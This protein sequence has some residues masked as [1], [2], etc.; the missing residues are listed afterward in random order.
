MKINAVVVDDEKEA[1]EGVS[2]LLQQDSAIKIAAICGDGVSAIEQIN[3]FEPQLLLLDIQMPDINGF[4]VLNS[5]KKMPEAV[6]FVTA[7]DQFALKAFEVHAL[8]YL[9]KPFSDSRFFEALDLAKKRIAQKRLSDFKHLL[10]TVDTSGST[11]LDRNDQ[12]IVKSDGKIHLLPHA[13]IL[14]IEA[15]DYYVKIH[16]K[17]R[18]YLARES[19]KRMEEKL[20]SHLFLRIHKSSI[21]NLKCVKRATPKPNSEYDLILNN[22][23][24]LKVSRN[25]SAPFTKYLSTGG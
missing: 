22:E 21:V 6:I 7:Y 17:G 4:E 12:L 2:L 11:V 3:T 14:W 5:I 8:D 18:F 15:Y 1:R 20:P 16:T 25:Y 10:K 9:L 24:Q 19:M 13:E 23:V